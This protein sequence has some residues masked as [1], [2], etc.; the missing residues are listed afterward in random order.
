MDIDEL[1]MDIGSG[2][3]DANNIAEDLTEM[4]KFL[5]AIGDCKDKDVGDFI[6]NNWENI[7]DIVDRYKDVS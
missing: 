6:Y 1:A 3:V 5:S 2:D 7:E 4:A